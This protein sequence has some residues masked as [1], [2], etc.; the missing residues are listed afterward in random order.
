[1]SEG[2]ATELRLIRKVLIGGDEDAPS[3]YRQIIPAPGWRAWFWEGDQLEM[4]P[5][6]AWA[7]TA[8]GAVVALITGGGREVIEL[9]EDIGQ[10]LIAICGPGEKEP[11]AAEARARFEAIERFVATHEEGT[12]RTGGPVP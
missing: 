9:D 7:L 8:S 6:V 11:T 2:I 12:A 3:R 4:Q 1:M 10:S 5:L